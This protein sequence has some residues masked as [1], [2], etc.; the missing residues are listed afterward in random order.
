[1]GYVHLGHG[2]STNLEHT[3]GSPQINFGTP[4]AGIMVLLLFRVRVLTQKYQATSLID[5][6]DMVSSYTED[7]LGCKRTLIRPNHVT[8]SAFYDVLVCFKEREKG[9]INRSDFWEYFF[10]I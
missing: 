8:Y 6:M 1:M 9:P 10:E 7:I 4:S 2:V 5:Q 3:V